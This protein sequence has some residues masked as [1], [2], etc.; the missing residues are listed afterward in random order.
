M[1]TF[2]ALLRLTQTD[3]GLLHIHLL[4]ILKDRCLTEFFLDLI[5]RTV[6]GGAAGLH[7]IDI[8]FQ[9]VHVL[10]QERDCFLELFDLAPAAQQIAGILKRSSGHGAARIDQ[11]PLQ[12]H[13]AQ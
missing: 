12:C 9:R 8:L 3:L 6:A 2:A 11:F 4:C 10:F 13:D 5:N 7:F 1:E